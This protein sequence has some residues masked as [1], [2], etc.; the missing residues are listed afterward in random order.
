MAA[1]AHAEGSRAQ[2]R[3]L[4]REPAKEAFRSAHRPEHQFPPYQVLGPG[5]ANY[6]VVGE[7]FREQQ[8]IAAL[9][10]LVPDVEKTVEDAI[11]HLIPEPENPHGYGNAVMVW[12]NGQHVGYLSN[13]DARRYRPILDTI[14]AAGYLP[15]TTG[16]IWGV[17]RI[18]WE[19]K[20][21]HHL[22]ARVALNEPD[23][24][25]PTNNPPSSPYSLMPWGPAIQVTKESDHLPELIE[26]LHGPDSYA[27][28]VLKEASRVLKNGT[29]REYVTVHL[30]GDEIGELTPTMSEKI[31]PTVRHLSDLGF[32]A[33]A[34]ARVKGSV[35][36]VEVTLQVAKAHELPEAW[37]SEIPVTVPSLLPVG[38]QSE[39]GT[40]PSIPANTAAETDRADQQRR[41]D[42]WEF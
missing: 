8:V 4:Q 11:T 28:A 42:T 16:R 15:T 9:G 20:P 25:L 22:Y 35:L 6:E 2:R 37:L 39:K 31:L 27:I 38:Q 18:D 40:S 32:A 17:T 14:V 5:Y 13:E 10:G 19:G 24:L 23:L 36:A 12:I 3:P 21:K 34:W 33:A 7:S 1:V 26:H 41:E 30:G 29:V